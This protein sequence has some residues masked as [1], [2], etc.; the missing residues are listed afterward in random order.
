M[1]IEFLYLGV[2]FAICVIWFSIL[3]RPLYE[4]ML[5]SFVALI[6]TVAIVTG[7]FSFAAVWGYIWDAMT[8][9]S[10]YVIFVFI[11][12]AAL[13]S[14]TSVIDDCIAIILSIFGRFRGGAGFVAII[15]SSYMGSLSGSGPGNVATTGVFTIPAMIKSGFPPHLAANVEAHSST[16]G[17]MIPPAGMV[18]IAFDHLAKSKWGESF[19]MSQFWIVLWGIAI[20]F[21]LQRILTLYFMC[22]YYKVEAMKKEDIPSF[23]ASI[24]KGWKAVFL[25]IIVFLPFMLNSMFEEFFSTQLGAKATSIANSILLLIPSLIVIMGIFLS[26]KETKQRMTPKNIY[27]YIEKGMLKV[28]PTAALVLFAY[29]VSNVLE[30]LNVEQAIGEFISGFNLPKLALVII[31]PLFTMILG[32][33]LP[34]STQVKIFGGIIIS[35][36]ANVGVEPMLSAAMLLCICGAMHGVTPPY[37]ACVYT[38]MGIAESE[39]KPTFINC[40]VWIAI[41]YILSVVVLLGF[42]PILGL[43]KVL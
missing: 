17:N 2:V 31:I 22:R 15:G 32:M 8:T 34:G 39:L 28:V 20:W 10:L 12:S 11:L 35:I 37:C 23:R 16:M 6:A 7:E 40:V 41:H 38:A 1:P 13:L 29:F 26:D 14:K 21:I 43:V 36:L 5:V 24:K 3:K 18:A 25:P 19:T 4:A 33:M 30:T 42:L 9:S 27:G